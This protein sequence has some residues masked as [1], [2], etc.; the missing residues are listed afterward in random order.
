M[1]VI[2]YFLGLAIERVKNN[3][4]LWIGLAVLINILILV[5]FKYL[6]FFLSFLLPHLKIDINPNLNIYMPLGISFITFHCISY[7]ID[8]YRQKIK[9]E[10]NILNLALYISLFPHLIAGPIVRYFDIGVQIQKRQESLGLFAEGAK[11]FIW[12]LGKKV[13]IANSMGSIADKIFELYPHQVTPEILWLGLIAYSLQIFFDFSGYSDMAIGLAKMFG[14]NF[15]ENFNY[16]YISR[17]A[18]E[19]WTRWHMTLSSWFRDYVYIPLGGDRKGLLRTCLNILIVFLLTGFWHGASWHF[20]FWGL[21][22]GVIL[23][24]ERLFLGKWL[25]WAWRPISHFYALLVIMIG[26]LFFRVESIQ[27][28]FFLLKQLFLLGPKNNPIYTLNTFLTPEIIAIFLIGI[29]LCVPIHPIV[30]KKLD[31]KKPDWISGSIGAMSLIT[32]LLVFLYSILRL[33]ADTYNPFIY[34]RF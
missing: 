30:A 22:F 21:Y 31:F 18:R 28:A 19:F 29:L 25:N 8:V 9:P 32:T 2:N 3:S 11:R 15:V 17:S 6:I 20:M 24:L 13:I 33:I 34:F 10:K 14:F 23:C 1:V 4:R 12:G 27:Y 5:Y 16:P 7:C 26:W